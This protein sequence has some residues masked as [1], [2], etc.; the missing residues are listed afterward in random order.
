MD[1]AFTDEGAAE[2]VELK[3][4]GVDDDVEVSRNDHGEVDDVGHA[5]DE[6]FF[7]RLPAPSCELTANLL[8]SI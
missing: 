2:S 5:V 3:P 6:V 4:E 7:P 8:L 1:I